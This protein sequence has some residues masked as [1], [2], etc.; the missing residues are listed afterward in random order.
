MR[1]ITLLLV[2]MLILTACGDVKENEV[3]NNQENSEPV[4]DLQND[5]YEKTEP[6]IEEKKEDIDKAIETVLPEVKPEEETKIVL[7]SVKEEISKKD[8]AKIEIQPPSEEQPKEVVIEYEEGVEV[9]K[10]ASDFEVELLNGEKVKLS[11]YFGKP[12]FLNFWATWCGPCVSEMPDIE[13]MKKEYED[14][15]VILLV[16]G[17]EEK[18]DVEYFINR[19]G[20]TSLVGLDKTGEILTKY[21]SM[22]IPLSVFIDKD[23]IIRERK[24]GAMT[25]ENMREII[26]KLI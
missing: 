23:G 18:E 19:M 7:E 21:D 13:K 9:G 3:V 26:S 8:E 17:G 5:E 22:Y 24:V 11:S 14:D 2:V 6:D 4:V 25:E 10:K 1:K 12:I 20:Y 15:L 16:N